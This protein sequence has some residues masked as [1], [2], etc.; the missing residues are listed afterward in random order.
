MSAH[1][2]QCRR[3][4]APQPGTQACVAVS[5]VR[6]VCFAQE[7][8]GIK[9]CLSLPPRSTALGLLLPHLVSGDGADQKLAKAFELVA[10]LA[11]RS[12][13]LR[14]QFPGLVG[15]GLSNDPDRV[16]DLATGV[17]TMFLSRTQGS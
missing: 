5:S 7:E 13:A 16:G 12:L 17:Q 4:E 2:S 9:V 10:A 14:V 15:S 11:V 6:F 1:R 8:K 3:R